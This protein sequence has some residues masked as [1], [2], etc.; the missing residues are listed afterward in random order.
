MSVLLP[1][2]ILVTVRFAFCTLICG[3]GVVAGVALSDVFST[4]TL[5]QHPFG[6]VMIAVDVTLKYS[7]AAAGVTIALDVRIGSPSIA[8]ATLIGAAVPEGGTA[9]FPLNVT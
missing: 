7:S 4:D 3:A 2:A 5:K 1:Y 8:S 9:M 6:I